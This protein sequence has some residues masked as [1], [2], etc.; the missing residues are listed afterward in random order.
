[1]TVS[2]RVM[3][4]DTPAAR[5]IDVELSQDATVKDALVEYLSIIDLGVELSALCTSQF[6]VNGKACSVKQAL[7][8]D[9]RLTVIRLLGG[10]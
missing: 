5:D 1:M 7:N 10:G 6:I 2:M 4:Y 9:D 3:G 8:D